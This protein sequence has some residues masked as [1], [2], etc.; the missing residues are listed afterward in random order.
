MCR[1]LTSHTTC[2]DAL[3]VLYPGMYVLSACLFALTRLAMVA[4]GPGSYQALKQRGGPDEVA[5]RPGQ[6]PYRTWHRVYCGS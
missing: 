5:S 2:A 1:V 3:M 4:A 6:N